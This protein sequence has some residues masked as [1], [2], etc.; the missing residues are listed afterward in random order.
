MRILVN[1]RLFKFAWK[2]L[3]QPEL[4]SV[5][6]PTEW[7]IIGNLV[8]DPRVDRVV[9][10]DG[11]VV[12][13]LDE[14]YAGCARSVPFVPSRVQFLSTDLLEGGVGVR[15]FTSIYILGEDA[16]AVKNSWA[17][18]IDKA[19]HRIESVQPIYPGTQDVYRVDY[20]AF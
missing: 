10:T 4:R 7:P 20:N 12:K 6:S 18:E 14:F 5:P 2:A 11:A 13:D 8:Y 16:N 1:K 15:E 17:I 9:D 3:K 19:L